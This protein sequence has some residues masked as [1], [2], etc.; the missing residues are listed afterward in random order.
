M[1]A[2]WSS[3]SRFEGC[4]SPSLSVDSFPESV[5][6]PESKGSPDS[7]VSPE[8]TS[9]SLSSGSNGLSLIGYLLSEQLSRRLNIVS[10]ENFKGMLPKMG[11]H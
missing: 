2:S 5:V 6:S 10:R 3:Q 1:L 11:F 8:S 9:E 7:E 4:P